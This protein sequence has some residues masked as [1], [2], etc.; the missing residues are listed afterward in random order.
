M[1]YNKLI[2][3]G[4]SFVYD[5]HD[6]EDIERKSQPYFINKLLE[7]YPNKN[8]WEIDEIISKKFPSYNSN[9]HQRTWP[10]LL[11]TFL[12][13]KIHNF[14]IGGNSNP[15]IFRDVSNYLITNQNETNNLVIVGTTALNRIN[16]WLDYKQEYINLHLKDFD[17]IEDLYSS[18]LFDN[19]KDLV[20]Y[21]MLYLKYFHDEEES[22]YQVQK[23][24]DLLKYI[25]KEQNHK[26]LIFD[27]LIFSASRNKRI[28]GSKDKLKDK[29]IKD[30]DKNLIYFK[31]N[32]FCFPEYIK[33]YDSKYRLSHLNTKDHE[34][35]FNIIKD[36]I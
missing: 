23:N 29:F 15:K 28:I 25:C 18:H 4:C 26:L 22:L 32:I 2:V 35:L 3:G 12:N 31:D 11:S 20:D 8:K 21:Q 16:R 13:T 7:E 1:K 33:C 19:P 24:I 36:K 17:K 6:T 27:N 30:N 14:S 9:F 10:F 34:I 5:C